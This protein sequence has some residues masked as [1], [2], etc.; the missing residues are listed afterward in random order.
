[1]NLYRYKALDLTGKIIKGLVR[2]ENEG[3]ALSALVMRNLYVLSFTKLP[4]LFTPF[5]EIFTKKIKNGE[6]IEFTRN[7]S[8]MIK[9]GIP[10]NHALADIAENTL[11]KRFA[12]IILDLRDFIESGS[13]FS[14]AIAHHR[15]VFPPIFCNVIRI[16]EETGNLDECLNDLADHFQR[17]EDLRTTIKRALTYPLFAIVASFGAIGFW[18]IYV[19]PKVIDALKGVGVKIPFITKVLVNIGALLGKFFYLVP[20]LPLFLAIAYQVLKKNEKFRWIKSH[21]SFKLPI[22][23]Q[24]YYTRSVALF[25]EQMR[26]LTKSGILVDRA[27]EMTAEAI[28]N[29]LMKRAVRN[30]REKVITGQGIA[31]SLREENLFPPMLIRLVQVGEISGNLDEQFGFL[32]THYTNY[33]INY[34]DRL[35]KIIEPVVIGVIGFFFAIIL[36]SLFGPLY[37]L[38]S[39]L[40][41]I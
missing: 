35:G 25:C 8:T 36:I 31:Q 16:G 10:L 18:I 15:D 13:S 22:F 1:M 28:G 30:A 39:K 19:L 27:L 11:N 17:I 23:K 5:F 32:N 29:E 12:G 4:D 33:L 40:G 41:K 38:I 34:S 24:I 21:L 26:L 6:L 3:D 14:E 20:I 37:E 2:A 9:A 7:L